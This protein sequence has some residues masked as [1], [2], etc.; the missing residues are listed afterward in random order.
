MHC[1][2]QCPS[3][4][5]LV[6]GRDSGTKPEG[7]DLPRLLLHYLKCRNVQIYRRKVARLG[8]SSYG[9]CHPFLRAWGTSTH[10]G[11]LLVSFQL[12][13]VSKKGLFKTYLLLVYPLHA[14]A[15]AAMGR[16]STG[17]Q[18]GLKTKV[19]KVRKA[20]PLLLQSI[21]SLGVFE[22]RITREEEE[23]YLN[24]KYWWTLY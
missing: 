3:H 8:G 21:M 5:S 2:P 16:T 17:I 10:M 19:L 11:R 12:S 15:E 6:T 13:S 20:Q 23:C 22:I 18:R 1:S 9:S 24:T 14:P 4:L 7:T